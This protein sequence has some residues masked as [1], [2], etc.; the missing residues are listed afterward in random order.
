MILLQRSWKSHR[1]FLWCAL[2]KEWLSW[3]GLYKVTTN[4]QKHQPLWYHIDFLLTTNH[5]IHPWF[6]EL[7]LCWKTCW[8]IQTIYSQLLQF[9]EKVIKLPLNRCVQFQVCISTVNIFSRINRSRT[10]S[11]LSFNLEKKNCVFSLRCRH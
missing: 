1:T 8:I 7:V 3:H 9:T 10:I 2:Q 11:T 5:P 6:L 4:A